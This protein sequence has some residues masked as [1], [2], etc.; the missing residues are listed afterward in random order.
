[1]I[2]TV[3]DVSGDTVVLWR[4]EAD[5]LT[6]AWVFDATA[7]ADTL[8]HLCADTAILD[9]AEWDQFVGLAARANV[10]LHEPDEFEYHGD[11]RGKTCWQ[12]AKVVQAMARE[13]AE[14]EAK[15]IRTKAGRDKH[16]PTVRPLPV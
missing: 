14:K 9:T 11:P 16:V 1:M 3:R 10:A 15:R 6:S 4:L 8:A 5:Q 13:W 12:H 2:V 7:D